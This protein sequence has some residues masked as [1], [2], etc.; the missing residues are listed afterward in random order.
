MKDKLL[1]LQEAAR[2]HPAQPY[3]RTSQRSVLRYLKTKKLKGFKLG[4]G[5]TSLWRIPEKEL[6]GFIK[7][8][9]NKF[10]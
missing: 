4:E 9:Q 3:R 8:Y 2:Q 10:Q 1:T 7:Y 6:D 5:R